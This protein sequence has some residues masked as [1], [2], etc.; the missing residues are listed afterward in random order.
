MAFVSRPFLAALPAEQQRLFFANHINIGYHPETKEDFYVHTI[1]RA[2][3]M[4]SSKSDAAPVDTLC[5]TSSSATR[6]P[7]ATAGQRLAPAARAE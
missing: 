4:A 2:I 5:N 3:F 1:D 6:P 7:R